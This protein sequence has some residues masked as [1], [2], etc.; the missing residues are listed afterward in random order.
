V[1]YVLQVSC[2]GRASNKILIARPNRHRLLAIEKACSVSH[3]IRAPESGELTFLD[4]GGAKIKMPLLQTGSSRSRDLQDST[5]CFH[6]HGQ[7]DARFEFSLIA[8]TAELKCSFLIGKEHLDKLPLLLDLMNIKNKGSPGTSKQTHL[9]EDQLREGYGA[10]VC[11]AA[12]VS[13]VPFAPPQPAT[14]AG[15]ACLLLLLEQAASPFELFGASCGPRIA[16]Q[17]LSVRPAH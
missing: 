4:N 10:H 8:G 3:T 13:T 16:I 17:C 6:L 7:L 11:T 2:L 15:L 9:S 5:H 1:C 14:S 12:S